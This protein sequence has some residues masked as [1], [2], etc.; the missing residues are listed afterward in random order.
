MDR[1]LRAVRQ[2]REDRQGGIEDGGG[3][4][5]R[6]DSQRGICAIVQYYPAHVTTGERVSPQEDRWEIWKEKA[7]DGE[8]KK[9]W[10]GKRV[11]TND[12]MWQAGNAGNKKKKQ[13][14]TFISSKCFRNKTRPQREGWDKW[15]KTQ[16]N[17]QMRITDVLSG[18]RDITPWGSKLDLP[19]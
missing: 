11:Q 9:T 3:E 10:S 16:T 8:K 19:H 17:T 7:G 12:K 1:F 2:G 6:P 13:Q 4:G 14:P 18:W 15:K 5:I